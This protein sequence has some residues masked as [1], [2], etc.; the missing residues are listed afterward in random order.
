MLMNNMTYKLL[1]QSVRAIAIGLTTC[2]S[3]ACCSLFAQQAELVTENLEL[4][5]VDNYFFKDH[6]KNGRLDDYEDWRL[7]AE[8][9]AAH[10]VSLM[11]VEEKAGAMLHG[12][13]P[14]DQSQTPDQAGYDYPRSEEII[15]KRNINHLIT[16][17]SGKPGKIAEQN[18]HIQ[19]LAETSRL[20]IPV[21]VSTDPRHHFQFTEGASVVNA[22][23]SQWP[24]TLGFAALRDPQLVK[25]FANIARQEYRATGI[26]MGLSPQADLSTEPRWSRIN[27]TFGEDAALA[28]TLVQAYVEGFQNGSDGIHADS[29][30]LVVKHWTGYGAAAEG[31]DSHNYYGRFA[32]FPGN[33]FDY[34]VLPFEGAFAANVAG[35]MPTYSILKDLSIQGI[36]VE[37]VGAGFNRYLLTDM[38]RDQY[39]FSGVIL[40]DWGITRDCAEVC[41]NGR[42]A[43]G[44]QEFSN[45]SSAW[46]VIDLTMEQRFA[47]GIDAGIDQFGGVEN[48][49]VLASTIRQNMVSEERINLSV[50]RIMTQKFALG[51]FEKALVNIDKSV[52]VVGNP[53]FYKRSTK[54][55]GRSLVLL[56]NENDL[57]PIGKT[58]RTLYLYGINASIAKSY[59]FE[60]VDDPAKADLAIIRANA[61]FQILHPDYVFG[62]MQHEGD[63]S[64]RDDNPEYQLIKN[65]S[66]QVPTIVTL[67][68]DRPGILTNIIDK[69]Q[70][71][72]GNFGISDEALMETI[73]GNISPEGKLPFELP[74]TMESVRQQYSD[75][76]FDSQDELFPFGF[77]LKYRK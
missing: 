48:T 73:I 5:Q 75:V 52:E 50:R 51:L 34:H 53:V 40:S 47:K 16:R 35:V 11:T 7:S 29:V 32:V 14:M 55:Q 57:L 41:L 69:A 58:R 67:Y 33:N 22:G 72:L 64:F 15:R 12:T 4:L 77:G 30:S 19:K 44:I 61:P 26:H 37:Q 17:I 66:A 45:F 13:L 59:G 43:D 76:P 3:L 6:N 49:D 1:P 54:M 46:G 42:D 23:F 25:Q 62:R 38:L 21:T 31:F 39:G 9:R 20:G 27:G 74:A 68:L 8:E 65:A 10:L 71:I 24:E 28:K 63:L 36:E 70:A 2:A 18:N 56:Q 60:I